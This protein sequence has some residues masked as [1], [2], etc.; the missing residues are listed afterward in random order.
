MTTAKYE[1]SH[2]VIFTF[3]LYFRTLSSKYYPILHR[4]KHWKMKAEVE[5]VMFFSCEIKI[6]EMQS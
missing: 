1:V 4:N 2:Y 3:F 6:S 5:K